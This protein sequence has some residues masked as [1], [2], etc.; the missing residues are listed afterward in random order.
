MYAIGVS[1]K[2]KDVNK[3]IFDEITIIISKSMKILII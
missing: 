1:E 3:K 2:N